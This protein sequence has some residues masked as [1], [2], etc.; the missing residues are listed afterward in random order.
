MPFNESHAIPCSAISATAVDDMMGAFPV[1]LGEIEKVRTG[2][3][4]ML[5]PRIQRE[6][7]ERFGVTQLHP[8]FPLPL[9]FIRGNQVRLNLPHLQIKSN[10]VPKHYS[11]MSIIFIKS[12]QVSFTP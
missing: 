6:L 2:I 12:H 7:E 4:A 5:V 11:R 8:T 1:K 3:A 9:I 10:K